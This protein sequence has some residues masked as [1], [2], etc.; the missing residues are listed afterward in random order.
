M[1]VVSDACPQGAVAIDYQDS[2]DDTRHAVEELSELKRRHDAETMSY[3][4]NR[5]SSEGR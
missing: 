5:T 3:N 1:R 4:R 2:E